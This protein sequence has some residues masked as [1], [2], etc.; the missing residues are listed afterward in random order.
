MSNHQ[1]HLSSCAFAAEIVSYVYDEF[2]EAEK[3]A[4]ENHLVKCAHCAAELAD[5][6]ALRSSIGEWREIEFAGLENPLIEVPRGRK[7]VAHEISNG[8]ASW[9]EK[10]RRT[11][12]LAPLRAAAF[13]AAIVAVCFGLTLVAFKFS[14]G[15]LLAEKESFDQV[16]PIISPT[17]QNTAEQKSAPQVLPD[18]ADNSPKAL[19]K[20][21]Q[22]PAKPGSKTA[23]QVNIKAAAVADSADEQIRPKTETSSPIKAKSVKN[24]NLKVRPA[25]RQ[26][27][28]KLSDDEETEDDSLRLADLF[29]EIDT[30]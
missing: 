30:K 10:L 12:T 4:L 28:P 20:Q 7:S 24:E 25:P 27:A 11:L 9:A 6:A 14:G 5:F 26:V 16:K 1:K 21:K 8:F 23:D 17:A 22:L 29:E 13:A 3:R 15:D 19:A 2:A 18:A